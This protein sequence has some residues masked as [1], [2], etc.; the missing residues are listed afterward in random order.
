MRNVMRG[1]QRSSA[2]CILTFALLTAAA[3]QKSDASAEKAPASTDAASLPALGGSNDAAVLEWVLAHSGPAN[4]D[5][6]VGDLRVA[7][8]LTAAEGWWENAADAKLAWHDAPAGQAHLRIFLAGA[9]KRLLSNLAV[10]ARLT[11]EFGNVRVVPVDFGWYPLINAYGANVELEPGHAYS[12]RVQVEADAANG[13]PTPVVADFAPLPVTSEMLAALTLATGI[14]FAQEAE[15]LRPGNAAL[16]SAIT[17]LWQQ[18]DSGSEEAAGDYFVGYA[19][20][21]AAVL[22]ARRDAD[23]HRSGMRAFGMGGSTALAVFPR[24]ART[25]RIVPGLEVR[26]ELLSAGNKSFGGGALTMAHTR[27]F[28]LYERTLT[29]PRKSVYKLRVRFSPPG[30]R[31]WGRQSE[32]FAAPVDVELHNVILK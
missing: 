9:D 28:D 31:R 8:T 15:L 30:F 12:L 20:G 22:H 3:A 6:R 24:D 29:V 17:A 27:W 7:Y 5:R 14:A 2:L 26:A 10:R 21:E 11:D 1:I 18:T 19:V 4:G 13:N 23:A 25:G 32:R 16:T